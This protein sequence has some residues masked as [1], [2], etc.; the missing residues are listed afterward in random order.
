MSGEGS[1]LTFIIVAFAFALVIIW[2]KDA[3]PD[4]LRRPLAISAILL[5]VSAFVMLMI[6]I[7]NW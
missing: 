3:L 4:K 2:Q 6:S 5:V 7:F 1:L